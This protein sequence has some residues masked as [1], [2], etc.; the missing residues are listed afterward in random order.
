[1]GMQQQFRDALTAPD[2]EGPSDAQGP[3]DEPEGQD[4]A[5][6]TCGASAMKIVKAAMQG[7]GT[8]PMPGGM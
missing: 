8:P 1:M 3:A 4:A 2:S 5:C 6:P 7:G